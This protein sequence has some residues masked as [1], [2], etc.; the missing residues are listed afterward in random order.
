MSVMAE[1]S[2]F[3]PIRMPA[4]TLVA[5]DWRPLHFAM[6]PYH[7]LIRTAHILSMALFIGGIGLLDLGL[8][9]WLRTVPLKVLAERTLPWVYLTLAV[10][11]ATGVAL[12]LY[13]PVHAGS[14]A[15][16]T[17]KLIAIALALANAALFNRTGYIAA[18]APGPRAP[19]MARVSGV[20][21]LVFWSAALIFACLNTEAM[22]RVLLR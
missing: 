8:I 15:Y 19:T 6:Q 1:P 22:P 7:Y 18:F 21:S 5:L 12:F 10:T 9:G 13:D 11:V 20:L 17:P 3:D 2:I 14:R 4:T 16:W